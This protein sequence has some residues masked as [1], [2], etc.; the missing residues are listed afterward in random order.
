MLRA[1]NANRNILLKQLLCTKANGA[2]KQALHYNIFCYIYDG[3]FSL[4]KFYSKKKENLHNIFLTI[5][6]FVI[7]VNRLCKRPCE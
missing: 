5:S 3:N 6:H 4:V 7:Y 2:L 1:I